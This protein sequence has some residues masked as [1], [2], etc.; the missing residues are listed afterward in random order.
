MSINGST[1][2]RESGDRGEPERWGCAQSLTV[3]EVASLMDLSPKRVRGLCKQG[4]LPALKLGKS[5]QVSRKG[6]QDFLRAWEC[7]RTP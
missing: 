3:R 4:I 2:N 5:W 1:R 7:F 6:F